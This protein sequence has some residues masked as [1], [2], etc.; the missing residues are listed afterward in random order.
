MLGNNLASHTANMVTTNSKEH[1][2][3]SQKAD[4]ARE[5]EVLKYLPAWMPVVI[6]PPG[7][8]PKICPDSALNAFA[9]LVALRLNVDRCLISLIDGS[10]QLILSE[11]TR[12]LSLH[13]GSSHD[14]GD[15]LLFGT[16]VIPRISGLCECTL[17]MNADGEAW[18]VPNIQDDAKLCSR[19]FSKSRPYVRFYAARP[20]AVNGL[21]IGTLCVYDHA[22]R[23]NMTAAEQ[24][25]FKDMSIIV[26]SHLQSTRVEEA[27]SL[28]MDLFG[29]LDSLM[30]PRI[31]LDNGDG[32]GSYR[33]G[34][35]RLA[36]SSL[37]DTEAFNREVEEQRICDSDTAE[38]S[39]SNDFL[40][41]V[42][43]RF[44]GS[45]RPGSPMVGS[46]A[47][48]DILQHAINL[49]LRGYGADGVV[50]FE[51]GS[52]SPGEY[53]LQ[54]TPAT[55]NS[56]DNS[57]G[58]EDEELEHMQTPSQT[59][60][61]VK[62]QQHPGARADPGRH[63]GG[64]KVLA[65]TQAGVEDL[66]EMPPRILREKTLQR[67][68]QKYP[69][70]DVV[71]L[72]DAD[73]GSTTSGEDDL[74]TAGSNDGIQTDNV[75]IGVA[76]RYRYRHRSTARQLA[77][78]FPEAR[79]IAFFPLWDVHRQRWYAGGFAY[80]TWSNR[81]IFGHEDL[82]FL[83]AFSLCVMG[84]L[85]RRDS[86]LAELQ[87]ETFTSMISH[88]LRS[89]LHGILANVELLRDIGLN[90]FQITLLDTIDGCGHSLLDII[91]HLLD[92]TAMVAIDGKNRQNRNHRQRIS[93]LHSY[94]TEKVV[95]HENAAVSGIQEEEDIDVVAVTEEI[96]GGLTSAVQLAV[97][98][99]LGYE[100]ESENIRSPLRQT[101][102]HPFMV[103]SVRPKDNWILRLQVGA[104]RRILTNLVGNAQKFTSSGAV[105]ISLYRDDPPNDQASCNVVLK[106]ADTGC[107]I[108]KE[109]MRHHIFK[110][111]RQE[112]SHAMGSGLGLS[113]VWQMVQELSGT[114]D[115]RSEKGR[116]T[117]ATVQFPCEL[118]S[119]APPTEGSQPLT[120]LEN[121]LLEVKK[122]CKGITVYFVASSL[123]DDDETSQSL[124]QSRESVAKLCTDWFDLKVSYSEHL[125]LD[126]GVI[127]VVDESYLISEPH[128]NNKNRVE[129]ED[130][131]QQLPP[132][133]FIETSN[134]ITRLHKDPS[135]SARR[136]VFF[137]ANPCGP[138]QLGRVLSLCLQ[139]LPQV[140]HTQIETTT[141]NRAAETV[142]KLPDR[143]TTVLPVWKPEHDASIQERRGDG[144]S[145][146]PKPEP[147]TR[148]IVH[149]MN[150]DTANFDLPDGKASPF[151][152]LVEDNAINMRIL[153][154]AAKKLKVDY[155]MAFDGQQA[156]DLFAEAP[157]KYD[158]IWMDI[159]MPQSKS[160]SG[161]ITQALLTTASEWNQCH[162]AHTRDREEVPENR[163]QASGSNRRFDRNEWTRNRGR[164]KR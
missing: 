144:T 10:K 9:Q 37:P 128:A 65:S 98:T 14:K 156:V 107:G 39:H 90:Q 5:R 131:N 34:G 124:R 58:D 64:C 8:T 104:Y 111:F 113:I 103:Y 86:L 121:S 56:S 85:S 100:S 32:E 55:V 114:V 108:S 117:V 46:A 123:F 67:L 81:F 42:S 164:C 73:Y 120:Y 135:F 51:A 115:I 97:D 53:M 141:A 62:S 69:R 68:L 101:R 29:A 74:E 33:D 66:T 13:S 20:I 18:V 122:A 38:Y 12:S 148:P 106:I 6:S 79:S 70:G 110:Q 152:M 36:D 161:P 160:E 133:I 154:M 25:V 57:S 140:N 93:R 59:S 78:V 16:A 153:E 72:E 89:P 83:S 2:T 43:V 82:R 126:P 30:M 15:D 17:Q 96:I 94:T 23:E 80:S 4:R 7:H 77:K 138:H 60:D 3:A 35:N 48:D 125:V 112:D 130:H 150:T 54:S 132:T 22:P 52:W 127:N 50:L 61:W 75:G 31:D 109:F 87:K 27:H 105:T 119:R 99:R 116:G 137:V 21:N 44:Q 26:A 76:N 41:A 129:K 1:A 155:A 118:V 71:Y 157:L 45:D 63:D 142:F 102:R 91:N 136:N 163:V 147:K 84:E 92:H 19:D 149:S 159:M 158:L 40:D 134:V 143:S 139:H 47:A 151:V 49:L 24:N 11:A 28:G 146:A 88:E 95:E 162:Q 145:N